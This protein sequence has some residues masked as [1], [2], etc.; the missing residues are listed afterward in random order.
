MTSPPRRLGVF[1][2]RPVPGRVKTR[3]S[4]PLSPGEC[5]ELYAAFLDDTLALVRALPVDDVVLFDGS[6]DPGWAPDSGSGFRRVRQVDGD[7]GVRMTEAIDE[8]QRTPGGGGAAVL[9]GSDAPTLHPGVI[10]E[11]FDR[12][13]RGSAD[14]VL[15]PATDGGY[16]LIGVSRRPGSLLL[17]EI[18]WSEATT[19]EDTEKRA[20]A[21]GWRTERTAGGTDVDTPEDLARLLDELG[22]PRTP[23]D[24][25]RALRTRAVLGTLRGNLWDT[26]D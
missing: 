25:A 19:L 20:R 3:L 22:D 7:L 16:V 11:A 14:L 6:D 23:E 18:A 12:L 13:A 8:L 1:Y 15:G 2:K 24:G 4:P 17:Q 26:P 10:T 9:I 21:L 5:A